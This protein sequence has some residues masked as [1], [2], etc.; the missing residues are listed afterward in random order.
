MT[1]PQTPTLNATATASLSIGQALRLKAEMIV[2]EKESLSLDVVAEMSPEDA[3]LLFHE[4]RVHQIELEMQNEELRRAALALDAE[5]TRYFDLYDM[6]PVSYCTLDEQGLILQANMTAANLL[7]V[8]RSEMVNQSVTRF[9]FSDDQD[10]YYLHQKQHALSDQPRS[11]E[12][13]MVKNNGTLLWVKLQVTTTR[14]PGKEALHRVVLA[15]IS[16]RKLAEVALQLSDHALKAISQGVL[17]TT[18]DQRIL[19][20]NHAFESITGYCEKDILGLNC[21]FLQGPLTEPATVQAIHVA[22]Q[23]GRTFT[24]EILNY[25]K[26]GFPFWN[27]LSISPVQDVQGVLTHFIG[28]TRDISERKAM[29]V[30]RDEALDRLQKIAGHIPGVVY[31][32]LLR[33]DGSSCFPFAS[34]KI[35]S[36]YRLSPEEVREDAAKVFAIIHPD[37][38]V[39]ITVSILQSAQDLT[40]WSHEYRVRFEDGTVRW[41]LGNALPQRQ[42][43]GGTLWHGFIT[44]ITERR[45]VEETLRDHS[46]QLRAL[47]RHVLQAQETERRRLAI[48]LHDELGQSLTA[49]K[50]NLQAHERF[51]D[52]M[53]SDL[54]AEN[55]RI[56]EDA[57]QQVRR[58]SLALRPSML[59][60]LG[61]LPALRWIAEQSAARG[62]F[63]V[64][65]DSA[66]PLERL[67]PEIETAC[68]RIVQEA[69]T[70]IIRHAHAARV[71]IELLQEGGS[72]L[73]CVRDDGVGFDI[74]AMHE[75]ALAGGSIGVLGMQ[76]R[77]VLI[78]GELEIVSNATKGSAIRVRCPMRLR[79]VQ[80]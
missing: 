63:T 31:Q 27:E 33:P 9:I 12:L 65:I 1:T 73:L 69:L 11:C 43:D 8:T 16:E 66:I 19:S 59:D 71:A 53:P 29:Q 15:D 17:I 25:R 5:R 47:S 7:G 72:L 75:R 21:R 54:F 61:L 79:G 68:F 45:Q 77:A 28:V 40:A 13:R 57:L 56:V 51:K 62:G 3:Q 42:D 78:G 44:D 4:L 58:L 52:Q 46:R 38:H 26:D 48:E 36:I 30:A 60:D 80:P 23:E 32:Y 20:A 37:D 34:E 55:I 76:E 49:I 74:A 6:A 39:A 41:L 64:T 67:A 18:P 70:N 14:P 24:G 2:C 35:K 22:M 10:I 50:I